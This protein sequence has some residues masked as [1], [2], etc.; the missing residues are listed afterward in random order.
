MP[1]LR[2]GRINFVNVLPVH[3]HLEPDPELFQEISAVPSALNQGLRSG[4]LD[5]AE[6]S[7]LEYARQPGD[8]LILADLGLSTRGPVGSVLLLSDRPRSQWAGGVIE[9]PFESETSVALLRVFLARLWRLDCRVAPEG[10]APASE[11]V[12]RLRIGDRALNEAR[13]GA[14]PVVLDF[15]ALWQVW[16]GLPLVYA[17]WLARRETAE[18]Q[19]QALARLHQRLLSARDRGVADR[20]GCAIEAARR[21]GG[22][23]GYYRDYFTRLRYGLGPEEIRGLERFYAELALSGQVAGGVALR[24]LGGAETSLGEPR[25]EPA[26]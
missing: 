22:D 25:M 4:E 16:T 7:S 10:E 8:Y 15:G 6:V 13:T 19:P 17:L 3:L 12:A 1:A 14:W 2:F 18:S 9:V 23:P 20:A 24:F 5:L 11:L 26:R 21:L